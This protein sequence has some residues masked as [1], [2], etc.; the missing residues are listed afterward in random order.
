M[1]KDLK[2]KIDRLTIT[3]LKRV[4]DYCGLRLLYGLSKNTTNDC[5]EAQLLTRMVIDAITNK[6]LMVGRYD[7]RNVQ[8]KLDD[9]L[10]EYFNKGGA[11]NTVK[12][13]AFMEVCINELITNLE[14]VGVPVTFTSVVNQLHRIPSVMN[15]SFPGYVENE[16]LDLI[17]RDA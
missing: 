11:G 8:K 1:D 16:C 5:N 7:T 14:K 10:T 13:R 12:R 4:K 6:G 2:N 15:A 17:I 3:D 9:G